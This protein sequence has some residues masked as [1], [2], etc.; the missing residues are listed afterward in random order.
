MQASVPALLAT[1]S[2]QLWTGRVLSSLVILFLAFDGVIKF[3]KPAPVIEAFR[4]LALPEPL[5]P[6]LGALLLLCT[7]LYAI[8]R[9]AAFGAVLLTGY[10][11]G[12]VSIH[13]RTGDP[14]FS[15]VLFP[16]YLGRSRGPGCCSASLD[17]GLFF[18]PASHETSLEHYSYC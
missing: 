4:H 8:P 10:L 14:L 15:H 7:L 3:I 5:A 6:V 11:G 13:L 16:V 9:T 12:A 18:S 17:F 2:G 1:S